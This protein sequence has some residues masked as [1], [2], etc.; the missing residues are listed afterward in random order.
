MGKDMGVNVAA[1]PIGAIAAL[2]LAVVLIIRTV[3]ARRAGH[4]HNRHILVIIAIIIFVLV[5]YG[6]VFGVMQPW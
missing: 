5:L 3:A 4:I 2:V 1:V 6:M